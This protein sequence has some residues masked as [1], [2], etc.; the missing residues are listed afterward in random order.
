M[1]GVIVK[2]QEIDGNE[3]EIDISELPSGSYI[4]S[5]EDVKEPIVKQFIKR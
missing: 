5:I 3:K 1:V 2:T 4:I